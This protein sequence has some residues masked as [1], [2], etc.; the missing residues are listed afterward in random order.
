MAGE[1]GVG[2][3]GWAVGA[4]VVLADTETLRQGCPDQRGR[5]LISF[6]AGMGG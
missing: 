5:T 2:E 1:G 4:E 6:P 3:G